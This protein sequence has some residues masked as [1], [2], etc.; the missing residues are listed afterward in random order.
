MN[1]YHVRAEVQLA[2]G[3]QGVLIGIT[4][5]LEKH[6]RALASLSGARLHVAASAGFA[7][8]ALRIVASVLEE[9]DVEVPEDR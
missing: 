2:S 1:P 4:D 5:S 6:A 3:W 8:P 9:D 7:L